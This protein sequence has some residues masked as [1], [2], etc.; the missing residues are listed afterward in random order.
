MASRRLSW[1]YLLIS[2][3]SEDDDAPD[4]LPLSDGSGEGDGDGG[5]ARRLPAAF[6][7]SAAF[8]G[9]FFLP[10]V[11]LVAAFLVAA[12]L[13]AVFFGAI[14]PAAISPFD[15]TKR[16]VGGK[17]ERV[18]MSNVAACVEWCLFV[19]FLLERKMRGQNCCRVE[20]AGGG[21]RRKYILYI[22]MCIPAN[23][24]HAREAKRQRKTTC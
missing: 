16:L 2:P 5:V 20:E 24:R 15:Y 19:A 8:L 9:A 4:E 3:S 14:F 7:E 10:T 1:S 12:F 18:T 6:F 13:V 23:R 21:E 17:R 11:F 22:H